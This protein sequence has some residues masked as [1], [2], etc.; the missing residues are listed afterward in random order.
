MLTISIRAGGHV[1]EISTSRR[2][3]MSEVFGSLA[4]SFCLQ[5]PEDVRLL[6]PTRQIA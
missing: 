6:Q 3:N 4:P 1:S 5:T 2:V